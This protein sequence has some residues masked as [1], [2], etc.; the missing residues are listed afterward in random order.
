MNL[1]KIV[2]V[3][4]AVCL[5]IVLFMNKKETG[6][7]TTASSGNVGQ[8]GTAEKTL[9]QKTAIKKLTLKNRFIR[10]SIGDSAPDGKV[11]SGILDRYRASALGG[12]GAIL[13]G[14]TLV[15]SVEKGMGIMAMYDDS[16]IPGNRALVDTVHANGTA[17]LMQLVYI[18]ANFH[19]PNKP[20]RVLSASSFTH[21]RTGITT[22]AMTVEEIKSVEQKFAEAAVRAKTAGYDGVE[23]HACH[24]YLLNQFATPAMNH[25]TDQYG[26]SRENR[27]RITIEVYEAIRQA[28]GDNF[29]IWIKVQSSDGYEGGVTN[30]D[31]LYLCNELAK[32]GIDAIEVSGDFFNHKGNTA[33]FRDIANTIARDTKVPVIVTGGNRDYEEM[34]KMIQETAIDYVGLARPLMANPNLINQFYQEYVECK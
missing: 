8:R 22:Y 2:N 1:S 17:I 6:M 20:S 4:L 11:N 28:V 14:Y 27:Y 19:S 33:Y 12:V 9:F 10:A 5:V 25:R 24:G 3:A 32:R 31:C 26:G 21:P 18:G 13:T 7:N 23:I 29:P 30:E 15:D 34:E 16:F